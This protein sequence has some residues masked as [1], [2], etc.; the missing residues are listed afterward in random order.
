MSGTGTSWTLIWF[1]HGQLSDDL[2]AS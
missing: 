1:S 2:Y